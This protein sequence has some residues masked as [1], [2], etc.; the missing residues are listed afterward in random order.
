[1][2]QLGANHDALGPLIAFSPFLHIRLW[3][4]Y[5]KKVPERIR[6]FL[7]FRG[8]LCPVELGE[9]MAAAHTPRR[10]VCHGHFSF[11]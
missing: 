6:S 7:S 9:M 1:M 11:H 4:S 2:R 5:V 10:I 3:T 8:F